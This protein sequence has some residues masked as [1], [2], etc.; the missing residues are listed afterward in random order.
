MMSW[1]SL[2]L[3]LV[4]VGSCAAAVPD[5]T[6]HVTNNNGWTLLFDNEVLLSSRSQQASSQDSLEEVVVAM[7]CE[8]SQLSVSTLPVMD[9]SP[10]VIL[11][12]PS[13]QVLALQPDSPHGHTATGDCLGS[14]WKEGSHI[15]G[16]CDYT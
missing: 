16:L 13:G 15:V 11:R 2:L 7:E 8:R 14:A 5:V 4:L 9:A 10:H 3:A 6:F 12:G 1:V